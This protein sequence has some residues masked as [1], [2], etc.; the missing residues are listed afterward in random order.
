VLI[1]RFTYTKEETKER[2]E[3]IR[4]VVNKYVEDNIK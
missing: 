4:V 2:M 1:D 3:N